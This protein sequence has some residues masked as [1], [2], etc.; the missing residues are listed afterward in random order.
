MV[1]GKKLQQNTTQKQFISLKSEDNNCLIEAAMKLHREDSWE[2]MIFLSHKE[3]SFVKNSFINLKEHME[4][5]SAIYPQMRFM[6]LKESWSE[7]NEKYGK[8]FFIN[9]IQKMM[10]E[11]EFSTLYFH[12]TD[13]FF[14][15]CNQRDMERIFS[16]II[17]IGQYYNKKII[18]SLNDQTR[19]GQIM[20]DILYGEVDVEYALSKNTTGECQSKIYNCKKEE[21]NIVLFSDK[22]EIVDFHRYL[23]KKDTHINFKYITQIEDKYQ[24]ISDD[25]DIVI[26]ALENIEL[27]NKLLKYIKVHKLKT[28]FLF[29]SPDEIIRKR[30]KISKM[31]KGISLVFEKNFDLLEYIYSIE[32]I[33]GRD[34]Y[35]TVLKRVNIAPRSRFVTDIEAFKD[36]VYNFS[37]YHIYFSVVAVEY[38]NSDIDQ[39][40]IENSIRDLD[41]VYL[42]AQNNG[43][44]FL[45]VD[46]LP[47]LA[48][49]LVTQRLN[50]RG[51]D[52]KSKQVFDA[53]EFVALM[54]TNANKKKEEINV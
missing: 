13:T 10:K 26:F 16:D 34:F 1:K 5:F 15:G 24:I 3:S 21:S 23:F 44:V 8:T 6:F 31:Q 25:T 48:L 14:D 29:L 53:K 7:L 41:V 40:V 47:S 2:D 33:I 35:T 20:N 37:N 52:L 4:D 17:E 22:R 54:N 32:K 18:F 39:S 38:N 30:D 28:K 19:L 12:R 27:K 42:D 49:S 50:N 36:I 43:L 51:I 9:E 11:E 45:L 46:M